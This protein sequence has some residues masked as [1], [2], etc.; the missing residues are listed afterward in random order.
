[1]TR[2]CGAWAGDE[3]TLTDVTALIHAVMTLA[4]AEGSEAETA[5]TC[6]L[7]NALVFEV[8]DYL[9]RTSTDDDVE[10]FLEVHGRQPAEITSWPL[11]ILEDLRRHGLDAARAAP[12]VDRALPRA[13][14]FVRER[15]TL[16]WQS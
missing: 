11:V 5:S 2:A 9:T 12:L 16:A 8:Q 7:G 15:S 4:N 3:P 13:A 1:M 6:A 10:L 14:K